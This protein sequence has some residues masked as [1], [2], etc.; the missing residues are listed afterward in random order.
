M[1]G[2]IWNESR[3]YNDS[4]TLRKIRQITTKGHINTIP[5]YHTGQAFT[6]EGD[7]VIFTSIREGKTL[8][9]KAHLL[10][11][12]ITCL[13]DPVDGIGSLE[14][15][16]QYGNGKG[17]PIGAVL[18]PKRRWA[19]YLVERQIRA[20]HIDTFKEDIIFDGLE[21]KYFI[22]SMAISADEE[23]LIFIVNVLHP[24][25]E[26][27]LSY[28]IWIKPFNGQPKVLIEENGLKAGHIMYNPVDSDLILYCRDK[29]PSSHQ[30]VD[31]H[32]RSWIYKISEGNLQEVK[33]NEKQN[34]QTHFAWTW[35]GKGIVYHGMIREAEWKN[36]TADAGWYIGLAGLDG[37][38]IREYSFTDAKY[39]GHVSAM[40]GKNAAII[41]G[42]ILEGLLMWLYFDDVQPKIEI[43]CKHDTNFT[44][45]TGQY[46]HPHSISDPSGR[47]IVFNSAPSTIFYGP[48]SDI[49]LVEV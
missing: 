31:E 44:T 47:W 27:D 7:Y 48:R 20:V 16:R 45:M 4:V 13:I 39:Y 28:Q 14:E 33:T 23:N 6:A 25:N 8:L 12:D 30:R 36:N 1:K 18:S 3:V 5:S 17:I 35:D 46:A 26:N 41:D 2:T 19:Y 42:N 49:Y 22:E 34:F 9:C 32:S 38:P 15:L 21:E 10:T 43:V 29:G 40:Q 24:T 11:G 37:N